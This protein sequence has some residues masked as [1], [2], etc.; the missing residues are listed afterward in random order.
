ML[1]RENVAN[2]IKF[3]LAKTIRTPNRKPTEKDVGKRFNTNVPRT[4]NARWTTPVHTEAMSNERE[5]RCA[6]RLATEQSRN[7]RKMREREIIEKQF[8]FVLQH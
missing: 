4:P 1:Y 3:W 8:F 2:R 5:P 6:C 7:R